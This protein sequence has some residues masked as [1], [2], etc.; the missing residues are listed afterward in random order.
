MGR[1]IQLYEIAEQITTI[2]SQLEVKNKTT[3]RSDAVLFFS[4][5]EYT[6]S[7]GAAMFPISAEEENGLIKITYYPV[8]AFCNDWSDERNPVSFFEIF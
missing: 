8:I 1:K 5:D 6:K 7:I 4:G 2:A 3:Y